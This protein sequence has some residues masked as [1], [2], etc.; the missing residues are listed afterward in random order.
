MVKASPPL[1]PT[2][3]SNKLKTD[4]QRPSK[5]LIPGSFLTKVLRHYAERSGEDQT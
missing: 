4:P 3:R 1:H 5:A 2:I